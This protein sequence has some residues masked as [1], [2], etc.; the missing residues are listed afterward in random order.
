MRSVFLLPCHCP[1]SCFGSWRL[2][3]L[4]K[5]PFAGVLFIEQANPVFSFG[6][7]AFNITTALQRF[8][9][10]LVHQDRQPRQ[11]WL[12]ADFRTGIAAQQMQ[13]CSRLIVIVASARFSSPS[14]CRVLFVLISRAPHRS[15]FSHKLGH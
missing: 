3:F 8:R 1:W 10:R 6:A 14:I 7:L 9:R 11:R 15:V 12:R 13:I 2:P 5:P 4:V